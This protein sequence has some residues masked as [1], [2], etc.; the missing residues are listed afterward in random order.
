[1][2]C[3][4]HDRPLTSD[5]EAMVDGHQKGSFVGSIRQERHPLQRFDQFG[6]TF[7]INFYLLNGRAVLE[8]EGGAGFFF[9]GKFC[10]L[11]DSF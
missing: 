9:V 3:S 8:I 1:M 10:L 4:G 5:A 11:S 6:E 7:K 2:N